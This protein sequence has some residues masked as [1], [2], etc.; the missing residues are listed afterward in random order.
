MLVSVSPPSLPSPEASPSPL[1]ADSPS[2]LLLDAPFKGNHHSYHLTL[3]P[4][5]AIA[6]TAVAVV[7][8]LVLI[9]LIRQK[10]RELDEPNNFSKTSSKALPPCT[11]WKFQEGKFLVYIYIYI[12]I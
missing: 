10:S 7:M 11:T 5:I 6:V 4:G 2:Q 8:L 3:V 1:V 12:Y 9:V